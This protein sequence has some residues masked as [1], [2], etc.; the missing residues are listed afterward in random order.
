MRQLATSSLL[1]QDISTAL[2]VYTYTAD[3][4]RSIFFRLFLGAIHGGGNYSVYLTV[5][6]LGAFRCTR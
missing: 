1:S 4:D 2:A 3:Q 5:Q 6:R